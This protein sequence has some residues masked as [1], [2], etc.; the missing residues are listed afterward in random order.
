MFK[1][2]AGFLAATLLVLAVGCSGSDDDAL[3]ECISVL[4]EV[5]RDHDHYASQGYPGSGDVGVGAALMP[6]Q[7]GEDK[8][9]RPMIFGG[10]AH[11]DVE[12]FIDEKCAPFLSASATPKAGPVGFIEYPAYP[13]AELI[14]YPP[15]D[16]ELIEYPPIDSD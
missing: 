11:S 16:T 12:D 4:V 9:I 6:T 15:I 14:E 8:D 3:V 13:P 1:V 10:I 7:W 2:F 5:T